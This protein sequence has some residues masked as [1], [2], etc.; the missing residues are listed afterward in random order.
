LLARGFAR[1]INLDYLSYL[2]L[3]HCK[4][5]HKLENLYQ[6]HLNNFKLK[7]LNENNWDIK[8][9][10]QIKIPFGFKKKIVFEIKREK[11]R[12]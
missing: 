10:Y 1:R 12:V 4:N 2:L 9:I 11:A 5:K 3:K 8:P 7:Y 6:K